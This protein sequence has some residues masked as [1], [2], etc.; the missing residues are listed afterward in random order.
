MNFDILITLLPLH[1]KEIITYFFSYAEKN[2]TPA[3]RLKH[4]QKLTTFLSA[5]FLSRH[6]VHASAYFRKMC[7][8]IN[9]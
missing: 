9:W 8:N 1:Y 4:S 6:D 7:F 2:H 5:K 3:R